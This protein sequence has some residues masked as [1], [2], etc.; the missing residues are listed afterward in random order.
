MRVAISSDWQWD[1][2]QSLSTIRPSGNTSRLDDLSGCWEW[3]CKTA[4]E[5]GCTSF[6]VLGD[7]FDSRTEIEL[8]V[9]HAVGD[10]FRKAAESFEVHVLPGNHDS[11][12][13]NV[14]IN[15]LTM[16]KG[17]A[18]IHVGPLTIEGES[19]TSSFFPWVDDN[20]ILAG[21]IAR[22]A[23]FLTKH[24]AK[25]SRP[26][27]H[28]A[29]AHLTVDGMFPGKSGIPVDDLAL[30]TWTEFV[31]GDVHD[32]ITVAANCRYC[33]SPLQLNYGDAGKWRGFTVLDLATGEYECVEN[34]VSPR[35]HTISGKSNKAQ[36]KSIRAIDFVRIKEDADEA[37]IEA[38]ITLASGLG[39][40]VRN[41]T[42]ELD[43]GDIP[44]IQV[45]VGEERAAVLSKYLDYVG[46][47]QE[48]REKL[49]AM[50]LRYL[51]E[52]GFK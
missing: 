7:V 36:L 29:F 5:K 2:Y 19:W 34:T 10:A 20:A 28:Y 47:P 31:L 21:Q 51:S 37:M 32:P 8:P 24:Y 1:G 13:R 16:L 48:K 3:V 49:L 25:T 23:S 46:S 42:V 39:I 11:Y 41:D 17:M 50:G 4:K 6:Y 30:N 12:L 15:S 38:A 33:A 22:T 45:A 27:K 43:P 40:K 14:T 35:F 44:R 9:M 26:M 52:G 18:K